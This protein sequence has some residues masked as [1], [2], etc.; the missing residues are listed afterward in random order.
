M[1]TGFRTFSFLQECRTRWS[2]LALCSVVGAVFGLLFADAFG[3]HYLLLMR[4]AA[5]SRVS[6]V[7]TV[8]SVWIPF[9]VSFIILVHSKPWLVYLLCTAHISRFGCTGFALL[10]SF[11]S[12]GWLIRGMLQFPDLCLIPVLLYFAACKLNGNICKRKIVYCIVFG[13]IIGMMDYFL[14]S[15]FLA[16]LMEDY[17]TMG[18][19]AIHVGLDRCL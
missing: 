15:P 3:Y 19:Y 5:K 11:G 14:I 6:I 9:L 7:G 12:A 13:L 2:A 17:E 8:V 18:R 16:D 4:M 1:A 10:R